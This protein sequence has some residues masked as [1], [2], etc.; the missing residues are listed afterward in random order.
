MFAF[1]SDP[2]VSIDLNFV[3]LNPFFSFVS[4]QMEMM[5]L[6][7]SPLTKEALKLKIHF[8]P[9]K[10]TSF[11]I[12]HARQALYTR[13]LKLALQVN[14][15][16]TKLMKIMFT[17]VYRMTQTKSNHDYRKIFIITQQATI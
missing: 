10:I 2:V 15:N 6:R 16:C 3:R 8:T 11:C 5:Q 1:I 13:S 14:A 9:Q 7:H 12:Q 4:Q 17:A